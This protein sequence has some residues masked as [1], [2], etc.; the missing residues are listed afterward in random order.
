MVQEGFA[1]SSSEFQDSQAYFASLSK[2]CDKIQNNIDSLGPKIDDLTSG[3]SGLNNDICYVT[4]QIDESLA[5]NYAS[6]VGPDEQTYPADVQQQRATKRKAD[7]AKYVLNLKN[8]FVQNHDNVPLLEC[9][10][11]SSKSMTDEETAK[12][13]TI[14]D[15]L[16]QQI[17]DTES[18]LAQINGLI[19]GVQKEFSIN[20]LQTFYTTLEYNDKY[21]KQ[22]GDAVAKVIEG[23]VSGPDDENGDSLVFNFKKPAKTSVDLNNPANDPGIRISNLEDKYKQTEALYNG[24]NKKMMKYVNT[25]KNQTSIINSAKSFV[26]DTDAQNK[27]V[28]ANM[29]V[30][31][32]K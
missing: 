32:K 1:S 8:I 3:F 13:A 15:S 26:N 7:S 23:F 17:S 16:N 28:E 11:S 4:K 25:T 10:A 5:G 31:V 19:Q 12:L 2:R 20:R 24:L 18:N 9:F 30:V 22:A 6:N 14:R 21:L 29:G 27:T